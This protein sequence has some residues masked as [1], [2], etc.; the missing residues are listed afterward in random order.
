MNK[1]DFFLV[2]AAVMMMTV[3]LNSC[4]NDEID[5][6]ITITLQPT[7][8][9]NTTEGNISGSLT[10]AAS[11]T[12]KGTMLAYQWYSNTTNS[13]TSGT[14]IGGATTTSYDIPTNLAARTYYYFC[15]VRA[16]GAESKR[17]SVATVNVVPQLDMYEPNDVI[18]QATPVAIGTKITASLHNKDDIDFYKFVDLSKENVWDVYEVKLGNNTT[19]MSPAINFY[20]ASQ[21]EIE[22][23]GVIADKGEDIT[24]QFFMKSGTTNAQ[25]LK[26]YTIFPFTTMPAYY[27]LEVVK[28]NLN[29]ASEPNDT[30]NTAQAITTEGTYQGTII[31]KV[32]GSNPA[33]YDVDFVRVTVP[34]NKN[35]RYKISGSNIKYDDYYPTSSETEV[36]RVWDYDNDPYGGYW[37]FY[38]AA[39][40]RYFYLAFKAT[41]DLAQWQI[42]VQF[43]D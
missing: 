12:R 21:I 15:E 32:S 17:S 31:K 33:D 36:P 30:W 43:P 18:T 26:V 1:R 11:V 35:F 23:L 4:K 3:G 41:V 10:V 29:E 8:T 16:L 28:K 39:Y 27:T 40:T 38:S 2:T 9:T 25:Y 20:D 19:D 13:N 14:E 22:G 24:K 34:A 37:T 7:E 6:V 5:P 42:E